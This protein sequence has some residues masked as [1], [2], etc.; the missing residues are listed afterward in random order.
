MNVAG[1]EVRVRWRRV[2]VSAAVA[3]WAVS[4]PTIGRVGE[5]VV[6][7]P[8]RYFTQYHHVES[9]VVL[10]FIGLVLLFCV[11]VLSWVFYEGVRPAFRRDRGR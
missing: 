11:G 9:G 2:G 8:E 3:V 1:R 6:G 5:R 10:T 7:S 4:L